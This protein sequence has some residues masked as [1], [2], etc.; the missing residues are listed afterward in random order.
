M[1]HHIIHDP[2]VVLRSANNEVLNTEVLNTLMQ[3]VN[4]KILSQ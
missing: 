1:F 2:F 4:V 3:N